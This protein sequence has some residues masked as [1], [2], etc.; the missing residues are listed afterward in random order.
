MISYMIN[1]KIRAVVASRLKKESFLR[2]SALGQSLNVLGRNDIEVR[3]FEGNNSGLPQVYNR[4]I[5]ESRSDPSVLI[6]MHDDVWI[7]DFFIRQRVV[8]G[9]EVFDLLGLA[10]CTVR[11]ENQPN[12]LFKNLSFARLD[13]D[14]LS[15]VVGH[16]QNLPVQTISDYGPSPRPV[17]LADGLFLAC[18]SETLIK[19]GIRFDERFNF[20][21][22]DMDLCRQFEKNELKVGTW[23][24]S[25]VH[26]SGGK[27]GEEWHR[28]YWLYIKKWQG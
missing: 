20:H 24:I 5:E 15:G 21:F 10:G 4:A 28:N 26:Q 16:S 7:T 8:E 14:Q 12:W 13:R 1:I 25:V 11:L 17:K 9:L 27:F 6:F 23:P 18:K 22:Y 2:A 19:H 3:L